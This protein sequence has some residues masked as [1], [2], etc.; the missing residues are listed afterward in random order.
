MVRAPGNR[1]RIGLP[2]G[3]VGFHD[4]RPAEPW[5]QVAAGTRAQRFVESDDYV[6]RAVLREFDR[7]DDDGGV[8]HDD[9]RRNRPGSR[10]LARGQVDPVSLVDGI[11]DI[12]TDPQ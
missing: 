9:Q 6:T 4:L 10:D 11:R 2:F 8:G 7:L 12:G 1:A 3:Q 5:G